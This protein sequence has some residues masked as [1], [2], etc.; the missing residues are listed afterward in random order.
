MKNILLSIRVFVRPYERCKLPMTHGQFLQKI[1][2]DTMGEE[3]R[4]LHDTTDYKPFSVWPISLPPSVPI[5]N[6]AYQLQPFHSGFFDVVFYNEDLIGIAAKRWRKLNRGSLRI[7]SCAFKV[8]KISTM[9]KGPQ[10]FTS[11]AGGHTMDLSLKSP[12]FIPDEEGFGKLLDIGEVKLENVLE[13]SR[14]AYNHI[15][16]EDE[17]SRKDLLS[18]SNKV[19]LD[20]SQSRVRH[21]RFPYYKGERK[22]IKKGHKGRFFFKG[23]VP[24]QLFNLV[25]LSNFVGIGHGRTYGLGKVYARVM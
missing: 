16:P 25:K 19:K 11:N 6:H 8:S 4:R 24:C 10:F 23:K 21:I 12:Y 15:H 7:G 3:G 14:I 20:P 9:Y 18:L 22:L 17:V 5:E 1:V 13:T 2:F